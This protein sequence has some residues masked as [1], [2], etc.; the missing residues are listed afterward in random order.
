LSAPLQTLAN[1]GV[2]LLMT[3]QHARIAHGCER[4]IA[5]N[6]IECAIS[7]DDEARMSEHFARNEWNIVYRTP[8]FSK[9]RLLSTGTPVIKVLFLDA[10]TFGRMLAESTEHT[11]ESIAMRVPSLMHLVA[12][13][14]QGIKHEP[15][16]EAEDLPEIVAILRAN[17]AYWKAD[18][19]EA[20]CKRFGPK[21]IYPRLK[22][23]LA[24]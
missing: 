18:E 7:A 19:L 16:R 2:P 15:L 3:G 17:L 20:A 4:E 6:E 21:G 24:S 1:S 11:F 10:T 12:M 14:L 5:S 8:F 13:V 9:F 23:G 22:Q